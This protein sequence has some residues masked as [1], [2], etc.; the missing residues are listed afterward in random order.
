MFY[1]CLKCKKVWQ[2]PIKKCPECFSELEKIVSEKIKVIGV[3]KV[4]IPTILHPKIPYFVLLL[5]DEKGNRWTHK[6]IKEYK[7]GDNFVLE[8]IRKKTAVAVWR[9]KYDI[10]TAVEKAIDLIGEIK[11]KQ[12][13]KILVLPALLSPKHPYFSENTSPQFLEAII[14][15]LIQKGVKHK[16]IKIASQSFNDFSIEAS[17]QKSQ[18][19]RVCRENK[20]TLL[21]LSKTNFV[22]KEKDGFLFEISEEVFNNDLIINLPILKIDPKIKVKGAAENVLK[23]L[24]KESYLSLKYLHPYQDL[25][26]KIEEVLPNYLTVAEGIS[27]QKSTKYTTLLGLVFVSFNPFNLDRVFAEIAMIKDLPEY[28]K[29]IKIEDVPIT[30]RQI[31]ELQYDVEKFY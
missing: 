1:Q 17:A 22:K 7:I 21:D 14:E 29:S 26:R 20:V 28:L 30:G 4:N 10:L 23:F 9:V 18:L 31:E 11:I 5:E 16:N 19:L 15:Y 27:I 12:N 2:Y 25:L 24:K 6:S 13:S 8:S 3:S